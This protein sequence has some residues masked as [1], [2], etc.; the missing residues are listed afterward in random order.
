MLSRRS[1]L[2]VSAELEHLSAL[3]GSTDGR[4]HLEG[5]LPTTVEG[6]AL[7]TGGSHTTQLAVLV[8]GVADPVDTRVVTD[9][10]VHRVDHDALV[11]LV[12]GVVSDPVGVQESE[13]SYFTADTLFGNGLQVTGGFDLGHTGGGRLTV[14]DTLGDLALASSP[15]HADTVDDVS[16]LGLVSQSAGLIWAGRT[17]GTVDSRKLTVLPGPDSAQEAHHIGLL[18]LPE[19]FQVLVGAHLDFCF[20]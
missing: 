4:S 16:L 2:T 3:P 9:N 1:R 13:G 20:F 19:L 11:P 12:D 17:R 18:L 15:L 5:G 7:A 6:S 10:G 8:D 14:A